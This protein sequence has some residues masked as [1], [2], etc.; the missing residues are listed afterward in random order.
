MRKI[1]VTILGAGTLLS[2]AAPIIAVVSCSQTNKADQTVSKNA[3]KKYKK[4]DFFT[5][6]PMPR[7]IFEN[8]KNIA[9]DVDYKKMEEMID[10]SVILFRKANEANAKKVDAENTWKNYSPHIEMAN[11]KYAYVVNDGQWLHYQ[12]IDAE[13][14]ALS[15]EADY[16]NHWANYL[17]FA[18]TIFDKAN[19]G[20]THENL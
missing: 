19:E 13:S 1:K 7:P 10:E 9:S 11:T 20:D 4:S 5:S 8:F 6:G 3:E 15:A 16:N 14:N 12:M 17:A 2:A 18:L